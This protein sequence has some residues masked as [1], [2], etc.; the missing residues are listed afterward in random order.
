M[1]ESMQTI[2]AI[3]S[4]LVFLSILPLILSSIEPHVPD[5]SFYRLHLANDIWRVFYLRGDFENFDKSALNSDANQITKLTSLCIG[6]EEEDV[7]SCVSDSELIR[8]KK[9]AIVDGNPKWI[10]MK[11]SVKK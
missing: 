9:T 7:T 10:T 8:I 6:F 5:D 3:I 4:L 11:V 2:E 1:I